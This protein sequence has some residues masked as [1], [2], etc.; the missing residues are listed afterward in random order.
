MRVLVEAHLKV[1]SE[2]VLFQ[3]KGDFMFFRATK[4]LKSVKKF[5]PILSER[6]QLSFSLGQDTHGMTPWASGQSIY[7]D[8]ALLHEYLGEI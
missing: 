1:T 5:L 2:P 4:P 8:T 7:I 3:G 6:V